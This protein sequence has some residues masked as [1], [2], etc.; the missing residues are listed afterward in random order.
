MTHFRTLAEISENIIVSSGQSL[1]ID[2]RKHLEQL[3]MSEKS[4][5]AKDKFLA[6]FIFQI[7]FSK[8]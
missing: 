8:K 6:D 3:R 7:K 4:V 2:G 1:Q 5:S